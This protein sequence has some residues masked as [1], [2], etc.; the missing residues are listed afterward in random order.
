MLDREE[1]NSSAMAVG[2]ETNATSSG[3][4]AARVRPLY[5]STENAAGR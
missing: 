3:R 4:A 1:T 2:E 5:C